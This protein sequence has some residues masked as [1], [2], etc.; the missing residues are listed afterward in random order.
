MPEVAEFGFGDLSVPAGTHVCTF[1]RG[2]AARDDIVVPFFAEGIRDNNK[3]ICILD[4]GDHLHLLARI[5]DGADV[6][7]SLERGQLVMSTPEATYLRSGTFST[8][9]MID[10]WEATMHAA[11]DSGDFAI[12]RASGEM[13]NLSLVGQREFFRYEAR[14]NEFIARYPQVILCL[15]DL[16]RFNAELLMDALRTH[17]LVLVDGTIHH[18]PYYIEPEMLLGAEG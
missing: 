15:Y 5:G 8:E 7:G 10:F 1:F 17:P 12:G 4:P 14:L 11:L 9:E 6:Q 16:E 2:T 3:C 18:N 13:P